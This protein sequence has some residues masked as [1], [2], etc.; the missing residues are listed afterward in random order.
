MSF[1]VHSYIKILKKTKKILI[2]IQRSNGDV[3]LSSNL[4]SVLYKYFESPE[5]D[6]LVNNAGI[7]GPSFK[8]WEY[9]IDQW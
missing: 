4:I 9:P 7:A 2:I 6:I 1:L 8:T 3:F 5:I